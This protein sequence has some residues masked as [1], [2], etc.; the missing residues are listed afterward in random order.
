VK[1]KPL[2]LGIIEEIKRLKAQGYT[3]YEI[4]ESLGVGKSSVYKYTREK[5][6]P[7]W[8]EAEKQIVVDGLAKGLTVAKISEK[9]DR[10]EAA[11][12]HAIH[13]HR[14]AVRG[15]PD[16]QIACHLLK[17]CTQSGLSV[18]DA[19]K[20]IRKGDIFSLAKMEGEENVL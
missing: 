20:Q 16:I 3:G 11:V 4:A 1:N 15:N 9:V 5:S 10:S 2:D 13:K 6:Y 18:K 12:K 14:K 17:R 7:R 19:L 8:A